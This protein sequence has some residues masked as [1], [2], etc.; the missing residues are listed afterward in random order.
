MRRICTL[1]FA[2]AKRKFSKSRKA[3]LEY[4]GCIHFLRFAEDERLEELG[5]RALRHSKIQYFVQQLIHE[6]KVQSE[7]Q[8]NT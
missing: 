3:L 8:G 2:F 4:V 6:N 5:A 1:Y 7:L